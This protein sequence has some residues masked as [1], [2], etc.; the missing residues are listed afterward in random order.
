M[1][2]R[3]INASLLPLEQLPALPLMETAFVMIGIRFLTNY[4][5]Y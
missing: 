1:V 5:H 4:R 3:V 2:Y